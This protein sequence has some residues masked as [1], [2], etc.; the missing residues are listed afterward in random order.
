V[1]AI[2]TWHCVPRLST[3]FK[4]S[5]SNSRWSGFVIATAPRSTTSDRPRTGCEAGAPSISSRTAFGPPLRHDHP[6]VCYRYHGWERQE[7]RM[8]EAFDSRPAAHLQLA[9]PAARGIMT[10]PQGPAGEERWGLVLQNP[11]RRGLTLGIGSV[12]AARRLH[13]RVLSGGA[14]PSSWRRLSKRP[15]NKT[16]GTEFC[17]QPAP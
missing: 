9:D 17:S 11:G 16:P 1:T 14:G 3:R 5:L 8:R 10:Q 12:V 4:V 15:I 6:T 7:R 2:R 13:G